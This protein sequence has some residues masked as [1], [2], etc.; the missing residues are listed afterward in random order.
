MNYDDR[1]EYLKKEHVQLKKDL[2]EAIAAGADPTTISDIK[3]NKLH[4]KD[5]LDK[6][7]KSDTEGKEFK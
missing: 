6:M 5:M 1:I 4:T 7:T 3:K 2:R